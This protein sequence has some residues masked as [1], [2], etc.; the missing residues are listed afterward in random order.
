MIIAAIVFLIVLGG[1]L[2]VL[3]FLFLPGLIA[4][5]IGFLLQVA[6]VWTSFH[7]YGNSTGLAVMG[8]TIVLDGLMFWLLFKTG[9]WKRLT[10]QTELKGR[11]NTLD[12][13]PVAVGDKGTT[14]S[15]LA[16]A[17]KAS[18]NG[19]FV[20]VHSFTGQF[21]DVQKNVVVVKVEHGKISVREEN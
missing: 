10:L 19:H 17:G 12:E 21:I 16:P 7:Y 15:R 4:G 5:I 18:I 8:G 9:V 6:G 3:E 1:F 20:E 13:T 11:M 2:L 14:A